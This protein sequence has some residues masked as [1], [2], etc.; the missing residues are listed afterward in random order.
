MLDQIPSEQKTCL[1]Y[2]QHYVLFNT[3]I[4]ICS[5]MSRQQQATAAT[6]ATPTAPATVVPRTSCG[7]TCGMTTRCLKNLRCG[8]KMF[9][10][11]AVQPQSVQ[12]TCGAATRC[13]RYCRC[14]HCWC[15]KSRC[16]SLLLSGHQAHGRSETDVCRY[17]WPKT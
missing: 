5:W 7:R 4:C 2:D 3:S 13:L 10:A 9:K 17:W 1:C 14:R 11:L 15:R 12:G 16:C 6:F 8:H